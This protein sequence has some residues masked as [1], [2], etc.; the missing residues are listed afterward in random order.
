MSTNVHRVFRD[1]PISCPWV[2]VQPYPSTDAIKNKLS[3]FMKNH[4]ANLTSASKKLDQASS[5]FTSSEGQSSST[6][7]FYFLRLMQLFPDTHPATLHTVLTLS[8]NN[9]FYAIDKLLYAKKYKSNYNRRQNYPFKGGRGRGG[10]TGIRGRPAYNR[11][12]QIHPTLSRT[13]SDDLAEVQRIIGLAEKPYLE[14]QPISTA[15]N[16]NIINEQHNLNESHQIVNICMDDTCNAVQGNQTYVDNDGQEVIEIVCFENDQQ[17]EGQKV[18]DRM[19][20]ETFSE[21]IRVDREYP[22]SQETPVILVD[23]LNE[24][25][26]DDSDKKG[27]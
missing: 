2:T 18:D 12:H 11:S 1:Q 22:R 27:T 4:G 23:S 13:I 10:N 19:D 24:I 14:V 21:N 7:F 3:E 20:M 9:F 26:I 16:N 6:H 8:K 17:A 5:S 25:E 15:D